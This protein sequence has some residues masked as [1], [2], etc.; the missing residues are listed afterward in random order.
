M[1]IL[2]LLT[3][4]VVINESCVRGD[5]HHISDKESTVPKPTPSFLLS[6]LGIQ[7]KW[8]IGECKFEKKDITS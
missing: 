7:P 3:L 4:L 1:V 5:A 8:I 2:D 6:G